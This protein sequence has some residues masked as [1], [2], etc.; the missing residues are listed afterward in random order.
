MGRAAVFFFL[1]KSKHFKHTD[2]HTHA[3][4]L[5]ILEGIIWRMDRLHIKYN[6]NSRSGDGDGDYGSIA[7]T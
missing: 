1:F 4:F 5:M 7:S 2:T 3:I 6:N